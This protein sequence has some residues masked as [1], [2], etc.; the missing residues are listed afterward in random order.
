MSEK[1]TILYEEIYWRDADGAIWIRGH[2]AIAGDF[3]SALGIVVEGRLIA[4]HPQEL[5][6]AMPECQ[7]PDK[8]GYRFEFAEQG[9]GQPII[10]S[11]G[12]AHP[13]LMPGSQYAGA[14]MLPFASDGAGGDE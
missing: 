11:M 9:G 1:L 10:L 8:S 6:D 14:I 5:V 13:S 4:F 7:L 12:K 3:S 2:H